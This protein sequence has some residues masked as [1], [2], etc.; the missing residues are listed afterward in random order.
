MVNIQGTI[1]SNFSIIFIFFWFHGK[2]KENKEIRSSK[3]ND[4]K[5]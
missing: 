5:K 2:N 1:K 3:E 4:F